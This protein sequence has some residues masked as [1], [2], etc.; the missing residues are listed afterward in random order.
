MTINIKDKN[1][2]ISITI[3]G[4]EIIC[5][6]KNTVELENNQTADIMYWRGKPISDLNAEELLEF[7][8]WAME[9]IN[10]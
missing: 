3:S 5:L 10:K 8:T 2:D 4:K 7:K 6:N 9:R 1:V